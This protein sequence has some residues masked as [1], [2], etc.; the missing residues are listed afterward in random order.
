M[1]QDLS[2]MP[3]PTD[4]SPRRLDYLLDSL[5]RLAAERIPDRPRDHQANIGGSG[6]IPPPPDA[7]Q[8]DERTIA[9]LRRIN[10]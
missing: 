8:L 10:I 6:G 7:I 5:L 3:E 1:E 2:V 9:S 4:I